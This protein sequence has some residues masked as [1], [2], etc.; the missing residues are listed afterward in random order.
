MLSRSASPPPALHLSMQQLPITSAQTPL[1]HTSSGS[2][3]FQKQSRCMTRI[4]R[5]SNPTGI[6]RV[7]SMPAHPPP[8]IQVVMINCSKYFCFNSLCMPIYI[9]SFLS[10]NDAK[11]SA[12]ITF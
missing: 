1:P 11:L 12:N 2:N 3:K 8:L 6:S 4:S 5:L 10:L 9:C 7:Q